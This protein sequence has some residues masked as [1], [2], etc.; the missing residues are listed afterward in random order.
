MC[1][2]RNLKNSKMF[3]TE[4]NAN[5]VFHNLWNTAKSELEWIFSLWDQII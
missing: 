1:Q 4:Y 5:T 2:K 3:Q